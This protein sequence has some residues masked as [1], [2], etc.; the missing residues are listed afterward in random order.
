MNSLVLFSGSMVGN[1]LNYAFHLVLGRMVS[2]NVYGEVESLVS[3][4]NIISVPAMTLS[5]VAMKYSAVAKAENDVHGTFEIVKYLTKKVFIYGIPI[6]LA[7]VVMT[8]YFKNFLKIEESLPI[9]FIWLIMLISFF[10][11]I[12]SGVLTGWQKFKDISWIGIWGTIAKLMS[13]VILV[14][15]GFGLSGAIGSFLIAGLISYAISLVALKFIVV[16]NKDSGSHT[17]LSNVD[18]KSI[19]KYVMPAFVATLV[20]NILG[21]VDM[22]I[23]KHNL[24]A[25]VAGQYGALTIVSKVIFFG[26]GI[27]GTVLFSMAAENSHKKG[28]SLAIL[29]NASYLVSL[30]SLSATVI[31]FIFPE[32]VLSILFGSKYVDVAGYLGWFAILVTLYSF[33]NLIVQYLMSIHQTKAAYGMLGVSLITVL[34]MLFQGT[35][36]SAILEIMITAQVFAILIGVYYIFKSNKKDAK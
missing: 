12:S 1:V 26:T 10:S 3:L 19:A 32:V 18:F 15:I 28:N 13:M 33:L 25:V 14:K 9:I 24:D 34:A 20:I 17:A 22:V 4:I 11:S 8:P 31:Y 29:R 36:I 23:A 35:N 16:E 7:L 21:N 30:V 5:M 2:I 6:F 27:I